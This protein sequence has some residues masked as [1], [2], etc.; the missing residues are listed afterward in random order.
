[1]VSS[2]YSDLLDFLAWAYLPSRAIT[3][4]FAA[5]V[6]PLVSLDIIPTSF[7]IFGVTLPVGAL[8]TEVFRLPVVGCSSFTIDLGEVE[9]L[10]FVTEAFIAGLVLEG[11]FV[12][13]PWSCFV[14][15][16]FFMVDLFLS[17][18]VVGNY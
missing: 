16:N 6:L 14:L 8:T 1:M 2:V 13:L 12:V 15:G 10:A 5:G 9:G 17:V 18:V 3:A 7:F 11:D 4:F